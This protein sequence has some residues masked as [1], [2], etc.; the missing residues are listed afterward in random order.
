MSQRYTLI[1]PADYI[2]AWI[3]QQLDQIVPVVSVRKQKRMTKSKVDVVELKKLMKA[4]GIM[5]IDANNNVKSHTIPVDGIKVNLLNTRLSKA[6]ETDR[7][8][9]LFNLNPGWSTHYKNRPNKITYKYDTGLRVPKRCKDLIVEV[10]RRYLK[11][12]ELSES[13]RK[14]FIYQNEVTEESVLW[15]EEVAKSVGVSVT[16]DKL[17]TVT[18]TKTRVISAIVEEKPDTKE[19]LKELFLTKA[20]GKSISTHKLKD[21]IERLKRTPIVQSISEIKT[22]EM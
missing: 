20:G 2:N 22:I 8:R 18:E 7:Q 6:T 5:V 12:S 1:P 9:W 15:A 16:K 14:H 3:Q 17:Y 13:D 10:R 11:M 4:F 21:N 19:A